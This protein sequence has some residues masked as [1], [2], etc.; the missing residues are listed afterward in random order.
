MPRQHPRSAERQRA[1]P[2]VA[3]RVAR[4][5]QRPGI[6][7]HADQHERL[8]AGLHLQHRRDG[9]RAAGTGPLLHRRRLRPQ[10]V[11]RASPLARKYVLR[12]WI[13]DDDA[14]G[15]RGADDA[16]GSRSAD[17]SSC[18]SPTRSP[19]SIRCR[20]SCS[21]RTSRSARCASTQDG[22]RRVPDPEGLTA[23][24]P[25]PRV[26]A[27]RGLRLPGGE[28]R[29]DPGGRG[30]AEHPLR[31]RPLLGRRTGRS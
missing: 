2:P 13:N 28:E 23:A 10:P 16:A 22:C 8:D 21:T 24:P 25:R 15:G 20:S 12:S 18:G 7:R 31:R 17:A 3:A 30:D 19:A 11:H 14:A 27:D 26:H 1:D 4:R 6:R 9:R 5:E 29:L